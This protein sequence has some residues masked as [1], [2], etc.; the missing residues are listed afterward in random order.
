MDRK[1]CKY[2]VLAALLVAIFIGI[3][4]FGF[5]Q[6]KVYGKTLNFIKLYLP[7]SFP[8][9]GI[10]ILI[11]LPL[12]IFYLTGR[13]TNNE[14]RMTK[15][16]T[17]ETMNEHRASSIQLPITDHQSID[18]LKQYQLMVESA[19]DAIFFKDLKS[20]YIIANKKT[21]EAFGL[22]PEQVIGKN[23][24]EIMTDKEQARKNIDDDNI[25][26]KTGKPTEV[27]KQMTGADGKKHWFQAIKVPQFDDK[28]NVIGLVGIARDITERKRIEKA[29]RESENKHR[30]LLENIPQKIFSKDKYSVYVSCNESFARDLNIR[31]EQIAGKT[32]YDFFPKQLAEKYRADDKRIIQSGKAEQFEQNYIQNGR[33]T[34]VH[35]V[36][37]PVRDDQGRVI[38]LL[39]IFWDISER[40]RAEQ[41][42]AEAYE[43]LE[44]RVEERTAQLAKANKELQA[45]IDQRKQVEEALRIARDDWKNIFE[46]ISDVV[47]ILDKDHRILDANRAAI[48]VLKQPKSKIIGQFCFQLFHHSTQPIDQCPH[49][50]MLLSWA[51]AN[52]SPYP[53]TLD[54]EMEV[55]NGIY[56]VTVAPVLDREGK[57]VK[58]IHIAKDITER[59]R[60]EKTLHESEKLLAAGRL[61]ARIAH[62]INNPLAAIKNS[63]LLIKDAVP[64]DHPY[65]HYVSRIDKEIS[66][67]SHIVRQMFD[68]Y[69]PGSEPRRQF[70]LRDCITDVVALLKVSSEERNIDIQLD[71]SSDAPIVT[72]DEGLF[73]QVLFNVIQNAIE[74]SPPGKTVLVQAAVSDELLTVKVTDQGPGIAPDIADRIFEPFF[75][76]KKS[77]A[78][79]GLG[80]GLSVC[81]SVVDAMG[82]SISFD[83]TP[84]KTTFNI[85]IPLKMVSGERAPALREPS[86]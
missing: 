31:P 48:N 38:G 28:G 16:E 32:D 42:L 2:V 72:L 5:Q 23:D 8:I 13:T 25:V 64:T 53:Q 69:R 30:L 55:L 67:V 45:E 26:F 29:L 73:R 60:M 18:R 59:K 6:S 34:I 43:Q 71:I 47:L 35:I 3:A 27:T 56:Q 66:R 51:S 44:R 80:L 58:T 40:K 70:R 20:R 81:K 11:F 15:H 63:F 9:A 50:K 76:T 75:S 22:P 7:Y 33:E 78:S 62:E 61:A 52:P 54:I 19:Y 86:S 68:L 57:V 79:S 77:D 65:Y 41:A 14:E 84:G 82:G 4:V 24:Y 39:G 49:Q 46:S 36:K 37:T 12:S 85:D 74:A 21:L 17:R 83:T 10:V 1:S